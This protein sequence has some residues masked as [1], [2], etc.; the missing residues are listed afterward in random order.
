M[1]L[2]SHAM[3]VSQKLVLLQVKHAHLVQEHQSEKHAL[4]AQLLLP[5]VLVA[6]L[7]IGLVVPFAQLAEKQ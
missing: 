4:F 2:M 6:N 3:M 5:L 7:D 1:N